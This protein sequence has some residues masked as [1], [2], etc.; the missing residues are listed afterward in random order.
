MTGITGVNCN[1][2]NGQ[3]VGEEGIGDTDKKEN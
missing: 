2:R 3:L 1:A